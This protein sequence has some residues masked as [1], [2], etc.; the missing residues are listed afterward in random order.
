MLLEVTVDYT[1][2]I[3]NLS[4]NQPK[5]D[6]QSI[7]NRCHIYAGRSDATM[8]NND[9]ENGANMR[10]NINPK[11][12]NNKGRR[13]RRRGMRKRR[14]RMGEEEKEQIIKPQG[15]ARVESREERV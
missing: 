13:W 6:Q 8:M 3:K 4:T 2:S 1:K 7:Q 9:A 5:I 14:S 10:A 15:H 12:Q 11:S